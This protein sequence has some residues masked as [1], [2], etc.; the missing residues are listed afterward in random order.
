M[1]RNWNKEEIERCRIDD[2]QFFSKFLG[3]KVTLIIKP[4]P[5]GGLMPT[6]REIMGRIMQ[7]TMGDILFMEKHSRSRG[8]YITRRGSC[9]EGFAATITVDDVK[10]GWSVYVRSHTR[11]V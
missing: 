2:S 7:N 11:R 9:F 6:H 10:E 1:I 8:K 3:K 4:K 5:C